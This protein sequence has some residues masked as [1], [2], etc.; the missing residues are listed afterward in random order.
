MLDVLT[1]FIYLVF[2]VLMIFTFIFSIYVD[3]RKLKVVKRLEKQ[4]DRAEKALNG[5][6]YD[7][8]D[9]PTLTDKEGNIYTTSGKKVDS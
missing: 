9:M 6:K 5:Q 4:A 7:L 1:G 8:S 2:L 3:R